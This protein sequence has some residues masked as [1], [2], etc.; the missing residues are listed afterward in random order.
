MYKRTKR[1]RF[2]SLTEKVACAS[3]SNREN[4]VNESGI[5]TTNSNDSKEEDNNFKSDQIVNNFNE[6]DDFNNL[7]NLFSDIGMDIEAEPSN[8]LSR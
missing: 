1:S 4:I 3:T 7:F 6:Y 8:I 2:V 5:S